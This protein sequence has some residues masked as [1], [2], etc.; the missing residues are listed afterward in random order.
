LGINPFIEGYPSPFVVRVSLSREV[1]SFKEIAN[2]SRALSEVEGIQGNTWPRFWPTYRRARNKEVSVLHFHVDSPPFFEI[3]TDPA[4]LAVFLLVLTG[5]KQGKESL[6]EMSADAAHLVSTVKGLTEYQLQLLEIAV[7]LSLG[8][9]LELAEN[10]SLK[11]AK[12]LHRL[13]GRILG[14]AGEQIEVR[15]INIDKTL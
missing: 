5:Y 12:K 6:Q 1:R 9:L 8:H 4:W 15:V 2:V 10:E 13:R 3:L 11:I 14:D 7:S